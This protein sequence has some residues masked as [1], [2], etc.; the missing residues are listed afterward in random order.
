VASRLKQGTVI[1]SGA[2]AALLLCFIA[3]LRFDWDREAVSSAIIV[4]LLGIAIGSFVGAIASPGL[5]IETDRFK[6]FGKLASAFA[7]GYVLRYLEPSLSTFFSGDGAIWTNPVVFFT[8]LLFATSAV[9]AG[10]FM[11][12]F[13][14]YTDSAESTV[15]RA[16]IQKKIAEVKKL[17]DG[18]QSDA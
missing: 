5:P 7:T 10:L 3:A 11:Y 1:A 13:R 14:T 8:S 18:V 4:E 17:L 15:R 6:Q 16:A 2:G 12:V 9:A